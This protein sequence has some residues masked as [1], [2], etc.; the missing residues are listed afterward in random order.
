MADSF[1]REEGHRL[2]WTSQ[3]ILVDITAPGGASLGLAAATRSSAAGPDFLSAGTE[4]RPERPNLH[5]TARESWRNA[6]HMLPLCQPRPG[7]AD[8]IRREIA[9]NGRSLLLPIIEMPISASPTLRP[10]LRSA[11]ESK[12]ARRSGEYAD[13]GEEDPSRPLSSSFPS[14]SSSSESSTSSGSEGGWR[15]ALRERC[16]RERRS[17]ER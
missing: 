12:K 5:T 17:G 15:E 4:K 10:S 3:L 11:K 2:A 13:L 9:L 8:L 6:P 7:E 16:R 1:A 14:P